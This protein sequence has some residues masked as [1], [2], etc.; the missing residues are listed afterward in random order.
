MWGLFPS[1]ARGGGEEDEPFR[2][3]FAKYTCAHTCFVLGEAVN[4]TGLSPGEVG[5]ERRRGR[6]RNSVQVRVARYLGPYSVEPSHMYSCCAQEKHVNLFRRYE[7]ASEAFQ[8]GSQRDSFVWLTW[9][10]LAESPT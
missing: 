1:S 2:K 8:S 5:C 7:S 4:L 10:P 3:Q 6:R 9:I